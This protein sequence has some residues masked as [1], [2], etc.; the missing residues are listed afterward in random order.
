[1]MFYPTGDITFD[2]EKAKISETWTD[3]GD[4]TK[5]KSDFDRVIQWFTVENLNFAT[6]YVSEPD[7][8]LHETGFHS[9]SLTKIRELDNLV[10]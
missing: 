3:F 6:F 4:L 10:G 1:M 8:T 5:W 2:G 7:E 9:E